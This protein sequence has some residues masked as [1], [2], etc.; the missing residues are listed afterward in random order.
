MNKYRNFFENNKM[1]V[2]VTRGHQESQ[3]IESTHTVIY[4]LLDIKNNIQSLKLNLQPLDSQFQDSTI[5]FVF[6][7]SSIKMIQAFWLSYLCPDISLERLALACGSHT[8]EDFHIEIVKQWLQDLNL[9]ESDFVCVAHEPFDESTRRRMIQNQ[10]NPTSLHNNCSGKHLGFLQICQ[11][12]RLKISQSANSPEHQTEHQP[13]HQPDAWDFQYHQWDHPLQKKLRWLQTLFGQFDF[14]K[15]KWGIDGCGIPTYYGPMTSITHMWKSFLAVQDDDLFL[16]WCD[17][18]NLF[19]LSEKMFD[20]TELNQMRKALQRIIQAVQKYPLL[21]GG[22]QSLCS[23]IQQDFPSVAM[24][25]IGAEGVYAGVLWRSNIAFT[26]KAL[27]GASRASQEAVLFLIQHLGQMTDD[28]KQLLNS[29]YHKPILN[30]AG[31]PVG[32]TFVF[33]P[34]S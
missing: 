7:R 22:H 20:A 12:Q 18:L 3:A 11:T 26:V 28:E 32:D 6:P 29:K 8:G 1:T 10:V 17:E 5:P 27:D 4:H 21:I 30:W 9:S 13:E 2:A 25:K 31:V 34:S 16:K 15:S 23:K 33:L 14:M 19:G 24:I